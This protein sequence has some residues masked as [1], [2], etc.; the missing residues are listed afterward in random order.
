VHQ[1]LHGARD[2]AVVHEEILV[3]VEPGIATLEI[4]GSVAGHAM[5]QREVLCPGRRPDGVGLHESHGVEG[6]L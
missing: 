1:H 5:T 3:D 6:T 4:A 2:K